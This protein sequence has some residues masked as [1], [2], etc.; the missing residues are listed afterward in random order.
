VAGGP[1]MRFDTNTCYVSKNNQYN[2]ISIK[3]ALQK[4]LRGTC[5]RI[6]AIDTTPQLGYVYDYISCGEQELE[7]ME[8]FLAAEQDRMAGIKGHSIDQFAKNMK[9]AIEEG[10]KTAAFFKKSSRVYLS[11]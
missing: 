2:T 6:V 5:L 7:Q 8:R 3:T 11:K 9:K 1:Q 10:M 4:T